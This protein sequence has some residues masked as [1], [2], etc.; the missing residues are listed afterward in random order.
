MELQRFPV[1][2]TVGMHSGKFLCDLTL[3]EEERVPTRLTVVLDSESGQLCS[4]QKMGGAAVSPEQ[5]A[6]V[7][8]LGNARRKQVD[9]A[10]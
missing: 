4:L 9:L 5:L 6:Q 7:L 1:P 2:L 10:R 8:A 3:A